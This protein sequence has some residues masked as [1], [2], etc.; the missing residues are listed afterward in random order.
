MAP[1]PSICV[2][3]LSPT[4]LILHRYLYYASLLLSVLYPTPP[5]LIKGAFA[6]SLI[7]SSTAALYAVLILAIPPPLS[8]TLTAQTQILNL[9]VLALWAVLSPASILL[10]PLLCWSRNLRETARPIIRIWGIVVLV[11]TACTFVLLQRSLQIGNSID[12]SATGLDCQALVTAADAQRLRLR[13]PNQVLSVGYD[14]IFNSL[15]SI[16]A[17]RLIPLTFIP[18]AFGALSSLMTISLPPTVMSVED[19]QSQSWKGIEV[20]SA[21]SM[22]TSPFTAVRKVFLLLRRMVL[23]LTSGWLLPVV[24]VNELYLLKGWP[25]GVPE[26]ERMYE[27][28][29]WG[30]FVGLGLVSAAAAVSWFAGGRTEGMDGD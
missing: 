21:D 7:Y 27:V 4:Y 10:L 30:L 15:Y 24:V 11:G 14:L 13:D 20:S 9:D 16:L 22:S 1:A 28:G 6:Y 17:T 8:S 29:Q 18:L 5:P 3:P 2:Y 23:Y 25:A 26:A 12:T 19:S